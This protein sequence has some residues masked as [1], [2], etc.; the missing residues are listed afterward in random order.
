[1][2]A[3]P[4]H[5]ATGVRVGPLSGTSQIALFVRATA[6]KANRISVSL[7]GSNYVITD[8]GDTLTA[9]AGCTVSGTSIICPAATIDQIEVDAGDLADSA[10]ITSPLYAVVEGG[11]GNDTI[12]VNQGGGSLR[13]GTGNDTLVGGTGANTLSG[14]TGADIF[15]G[16]PGQDGAN[17]AGGTA[18]INV[19]FDGVAN[20]GVPG[21][22][23]NVGST[24]EVVY[25]TEFADTLTGSA[26]TQ[27]L[28]GFG[29]NDLLFGGAGADTLNAGAGADTLRGE[30]GNDTLQAVDGVTFND[31]LYGGDSNDI[32]TA[33]TGDLKVSCES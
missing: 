29:G 5:A 8:S 24:M 2:L 32:C 16:G 22:G 1:M 33:D 9:G 4:A 27:I 12:S 10:S 7:S 3:G 31:N 18:G 26:G 14:G 19:T 23:D 30:G 15:Y 25:G 17:Y 20:D 28:F 13:G 11:P 21:E 6:G